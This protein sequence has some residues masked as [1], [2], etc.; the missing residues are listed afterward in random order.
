MK[1]HHREMKLSSIGELNSEIYSARGKFPDNK[2]LLAALMEEVGELAR[3]YLQ[4][5]GD[6]RVQAEALQVACVAMRIYEEGDPMFAELTDE[7][8]K[9]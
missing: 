3:A 8:A 4:K 7:Q 6:L 9:P 2:Y 1:N 5:Q